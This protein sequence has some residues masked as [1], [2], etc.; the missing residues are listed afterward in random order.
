MNESSDEEGQN[1][2]ERARR[3]GSK[4]RGATS[5][6]GAARSKLNGL[7]WGLRAQTYPLPGE[8][9]A[10][11]AAQAQW[12][13]WYGPGSPAAGYH[14]KQCAR[15]S[16]IGDRCERFARARIA[17][18]KRK[19]V[20]NFQRR[21]PRRV[22]SIMARIP[23]DRLGSV[24]ALAE[25]SDGCRKLASILAGSI[26]FVSS[27]GYLLPEEIDTAI[28]AHAIWPVPESLARDVTAYT[29]YILNLGCTPGVAAAERDARLDP[30]SRPPALRGLPCEALMPADPAVCGE[31]LRA[32]IQQKSDEYQAEADRLRK[33][34]DE[35]ELARMLDEAE[36]LSDADARR[37]KRCHAEQRLTFR[38][39]ELAL[40][41]AIE[42]DREASA[43][44]NED[45]GA[46]GGASPEP[47]T[48]R[49][50]CEPPGREGAGRAGE[51]LGPP[52]DGG[53]SVSPREPRTAPEASPQIMDQKEDRAREAG[54]GQGVPSGAPSGAGD[55]HDAAP[56]PAAQRL[57][58]PPL[59]AGFPTPPSSGLDVS[60]RGGGQTFGL[61]H[62]GTDAWGR[63]FPEALAPGGATALTRPSATLSQGAR[64][65]TA[66]HA[67]PPGGPDPAPAPHTQ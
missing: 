32:L 38:G 19:A 53:E 65:W 42:R 33:E 12:N 11:A 47:Q 15:A 21:G 3:N 34:C 43:D 31:R 17:D 57:L 30:A 67:D 49:G 2:A 44:R 28:W 66:A 45:P 51:G 48:P 55:G 27:R 46:T 25:F 26:E 6:A 18:Q 54:A 59:G 60:Q 23:L 50:G 22:K 29:L 58:R 9:D 8:E 37:W 13:T 40:Y 20:R 16:V 7:D 35:P 62:G 52:L 5:A 1:R 14:A 10:D 24:Q 4:G 61:V 41:K 39:S 36:F 56:A 63:S 64:D